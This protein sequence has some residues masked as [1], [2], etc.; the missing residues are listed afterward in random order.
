MCVCVQEKEGTRGRDEPA[1]RGRQGRGKRGGRGGE[2]ERE[3]NQ[4]PETNLKSL[5]IDGVFEYEARS[6]YVR[7]LSTV[8]RSVNHEGGRGGEGGRKRGEKREGEGEDGA[9][10]QT[11]ACLRI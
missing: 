1:K 11:E 8:F 5:Y 9:G 10:E 6:W 3:R 4:E 2:G 7:Y